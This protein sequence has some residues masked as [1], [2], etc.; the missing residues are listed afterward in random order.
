MTIHTITASVGQAELDAARLLLARMGISP[1]DLLAATEARPP[2]PTF[3]EYVPVVACDQNRTL[4]DCRQSDVDLSLGTGPSAGYVRDFLLRA[5]E[6][7]HCRAPHVASPPVTTTRE[8]LC[9][10]VTRRQLTGEHD[11]EGSLVEVECGTEPGV[12]VMPS[13]SSP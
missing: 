1:A 13:S 9:L 10:G 5:A 7:K 6:Q 2:A 12:A 4:A 3:A 8:P 11:L